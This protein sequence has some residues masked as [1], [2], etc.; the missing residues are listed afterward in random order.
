VA[1]FG[2]P[3]EDYSGATVELIGKEVAELAT[4]QRLRLNSGEF[5]YN[6]G[7]RI[8]RQR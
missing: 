5:S 3:I 6:G 7:E 4:V 2:D 1:R 8:A